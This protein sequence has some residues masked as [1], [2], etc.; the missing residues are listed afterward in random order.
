MGNRPYWTGCTGIRR[1]A[2]TLMWVPYGGWRNSRPTSQQGLRCIFS[3]T[4]TAGYNEMKSKHNEKLHGCSLSRRFLMY[5]SKTAEQI[6]TLTKSEMKT[7]AGI[8]M[9]HCRF[10]YHMDRI[11]KSPEHTCRMCL[12]ESEMAHLAGS[13]LLKVWA[14]ETFSTI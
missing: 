13:S 6:S 7:L 12:E 2:V 4:W 10:N 3:R 9:G 11:G 1:C 14:P 8:F 5:S